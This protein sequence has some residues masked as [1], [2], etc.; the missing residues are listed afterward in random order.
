MGMKNHPKGVYPINAGF[1]VV[2]THLKRKSYDSHARRKSGL[3]L[4]ENIVR[5]HGIA[6]SSG[7]KL[8]SCR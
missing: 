4:R 7:M 5:N 3:Y 1:C 2:E 6:N 8:M